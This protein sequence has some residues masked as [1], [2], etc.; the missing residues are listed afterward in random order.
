MVI[1][2]NID[3]DKTILKNIN[4]DI[5]IDKE[6]Q[7]LRLFFEFPSKQLY[8]KVSIFIFSAPTSPIQRWPG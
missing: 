5:D 2:E 4:I 7:S 6:I 1:F 3:I 8:T